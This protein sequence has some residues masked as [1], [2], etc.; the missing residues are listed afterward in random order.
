MSNPISIETVSH[1]IRNGSVDH[2]TGLELIRGLIDR[3]I[4]KEL[5]EILDQ[6]SSTLPELHK[7]IVEDCQIF[8]R[9]RS[10]YTFEDVWNS[11]KRITRNQP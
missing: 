4:I 2:N 8:I 5:I 10:K 3:A 7:E 1:A 6:M 9:E 11:K